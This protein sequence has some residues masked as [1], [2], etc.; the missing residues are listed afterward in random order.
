[1][2]EIRRRGRKSNA[3]TMIDVAQAAGVSIATVSAFING[4]SNVSPELAQRIDTAIGAIGYQRNAI[5]RSLKT[6]ATR[7]IGLTVADI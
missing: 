5:A 3:P 1:M 7:T 4:T 2:D 6:G